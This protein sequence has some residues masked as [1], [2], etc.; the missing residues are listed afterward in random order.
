MPVSPVLKKL[1]GR[2][3]ALPLPRDYYAGAAVRE[4]PQPDNLVVFART[5]RRQLFHG[6][7]TRRQ[8]H[9]H[10]HVL[11]LN[12]RTEATACVDQ[13]LLPGRPG[14]ALL[15][16]PHQFHHYRDVAADRVCWVFVTFE[17]AP[18]AWLAAWRD[19]WRTV[20]EE[21]WGCVE[22]LLAAWPEA[23]SDAGAARKAGGE[24][25]LLLCLLGGTGAASGMAARA[26][27]GAGAAARAMA[28][29]TLNRVNARLAAAPGR[30]HSVK[31][32][33][34]ELGFSESHLRRVF[35][36]ETSLSLGRYLR[37]RRMARAMAL[38]R[39]PGASVSSVAR[40]CGFETIYAFSRSFRQATGLPPRGYRKQVVGRA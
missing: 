37:E 8:H 2:A 16:H 5:R 33:A 26:G 24:L 6:S 38:L 1:A 7:T 31:A 28:S 27:A 13:S 22:R 3:A 11:I 23:R 25:A 34:T 20:P 18:P 12:L 9:H 30:M 14:E 29:S 21:G 4:L 40:E 32:L 19:E 39:E 36:E 10:R 15:V 17:L 35:R